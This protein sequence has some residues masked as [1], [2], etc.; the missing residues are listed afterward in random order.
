MFLVSDLFCS[1]RHHY[2]R[3]RIRRCRC[4]RFR[5]HHTQNRNHHQYRHDH[6]PIIIVVIA[7]ILNS[8][9]YSILHGLGM[10]LEVCHWKYF[11]KLALLGQNIAPV[12]PVFLNFIPRYDPTSYAY[13][14]GDQRWGIIPFHSSV[15]VKCAVT[16]NRT[17]W[18]AGNWPFIILKRI[19]PWEVSI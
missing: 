16:T 6:H 11:I 14:V 19:G 1:Y 8:I 9:P 18:S 17:D 4:N 10:S 5:R 7:I 12:D 3:C 13:F 2:C 15:A